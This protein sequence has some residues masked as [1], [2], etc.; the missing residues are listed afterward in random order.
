MQYRLQ[1]A[2]PKAHWSDI[3][4]SSCSNI[5]D[6]SKKDEIFYFYLDLYRSAALAFHAAGIRSPLSQVRFFVKSNIPLIKVKFTFTD[7]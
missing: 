4:I 7:T 6:A 5:S 2:V 1:L 3:F